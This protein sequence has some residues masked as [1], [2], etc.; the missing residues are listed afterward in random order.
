MPKQR[1]RYLATI[2]FIKVD[3]LFWDN[4]VFIFSLRHKISFLNFTNQISKQD[5]TRKNY[6][7]NI[8]LKQ[9]FDLILK[10]M[11]LT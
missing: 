9:E 4:N 6:N 11:Y 10:Y 3:F 7:E 5:S 1:E 8:F 2:F